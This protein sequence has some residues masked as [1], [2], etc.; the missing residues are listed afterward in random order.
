MAAAFF[1]F[2][3]AEGKFPGQEFQEKEKE[4]TSAV[5]LGD[6]FTVFTL[7]YPEPYDAVAL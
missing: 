4:W 6:I 3:A 1:I 5:F 7:P 2:I